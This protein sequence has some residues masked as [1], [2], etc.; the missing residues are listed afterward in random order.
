[1][2]AIFYHNNG[3]PLQT[4][5]VYTHTVVGKGLNK[6]VQSTEAP[7]PDLGSATDSLVPDTTAYLQRSSGVHALTGQGCF[8]GKKGT[9]WV[10]I[11]L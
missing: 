1:M 7:P 2:V 5:T 4:A 8:G 10:V 9:Y 11:M 3:I 6:Q